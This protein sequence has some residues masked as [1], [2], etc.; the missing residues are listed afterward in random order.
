MSRIVSICIHA[1]RGVLKEPIT[2]A[3]INSQGIVGDGHSGDWSRQITIL[4]NASYVKAKQEN[5][6]LDLH[7]GSF[8]ENIQIE[9]LNFMNITVGSQIRLGKD[10]IVEVTQIGKEDHPSVVTRT[11][12][13]S[14]LP[15]EGLFCKVIHEGNISIED[16]VKQLN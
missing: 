9:G 11:Y 2:R 1:E 5:P 4:N 14:L 10:V 13:I 16:E 3:T 7:Y 8:A 15:Y 6:L 12:G